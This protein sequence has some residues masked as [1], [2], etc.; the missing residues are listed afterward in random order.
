[1]TLPHYVY[2]HWTL[3]EMPRCFYVGKG[4]DKRAWDVRRSKKWRN[5]SAK[6]GIRV[7]IFQRFELHSEALTCEVSTII[8]E[9]TY[10][11][12]N[13]LGIGCN[14]T[15]GGDGSVG[16][17]HTDEA[18]RKVSESQLGRK[19]SDSEREKLRLANTGKHH[20]HETRKRMSD[21]RKGSI[22]PF[23]CR[24]HTAES[25]ERNRVA[26]QTAC[27]GERNGMFGRKHTPESIEKMRLS[28]LTRKRP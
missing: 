5:I 28:A 3:E 18:K 10:H 11:F 27:S 6:H 1:M 23:K 25:N 22:S 24:H 17:K 15:R 26:N 13:P 2:K 20:T 4:Q 12:D 7:E 16:M 14:F 8:H 21:D 19:K 9:S